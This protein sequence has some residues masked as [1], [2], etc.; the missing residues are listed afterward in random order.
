MTH[1]LVVLPY[2]LGAQRLSELVGAH[3]SAYTQ[4]EEDPDIQVHM[5]QC[6]GWEANQEA[7]D[8]TSDDHV[9]ESIRIQLNA[10]EADGYP[11][12]L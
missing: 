12:S 11:Q 9:P 1:N 4:P 10:L 3:C 6:D 5:V 8:F 2:Q 7:M